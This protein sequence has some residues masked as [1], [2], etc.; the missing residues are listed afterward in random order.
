MKRHNILLPFAA[1][2]PFLGGCI[3]GASGTGTYEVGFRSDTMFVWEHTDMEEE[4]LTS[5]IDLNPLVDNFIDL[6]WT[7]NE[8]E[9]PPGPEPNPDPVPSP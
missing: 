5:H 7:D 8:P 3:V 9:P 2:I 4:G 6:G 1:L